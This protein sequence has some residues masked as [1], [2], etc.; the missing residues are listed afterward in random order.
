MAVGIVARGLDT[1]AVGFG[2]FDIDVDCPECGYPMWVRRFEVVA[3]VGVLCPCC[4][5]T[6]QLIDDRGSTRGLDREVEREVQGLL[7]EIFRGW[8]R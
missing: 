4:R 6:V 7:D 3:Q 5:T 2:D 8:G 1:S